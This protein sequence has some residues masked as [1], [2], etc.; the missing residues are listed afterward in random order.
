MGQVDWRDVGRREG[1]RALDRRARVRSGRTKVKAGDILPSR[2]NETGPHEGGIRCQASTA[3]LHFE[4]WRV[5][6]SQQIWF[7]FCDVTR[8]R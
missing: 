5:E 7:H 8:T 2:T 3:I 1:G 4:F 6:P